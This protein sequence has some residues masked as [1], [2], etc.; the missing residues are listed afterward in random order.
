[1][2]DETIYEICKTSPKNL[3]ELY[4]IRRIK[5][6]LNIG[7]AREVLKAVNK[8]QNV[9]DKDIPQL[10]DCNKHN[11]KKDYASGQDL[12][13]VTDLMSVIVRCRA[14][15]HDLAPTILSNSSDMCKIAH[16][17]TSGIPTLSG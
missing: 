6:T 2:S 1:M 7:F 14:K 5:K 9:K 12:D 13:T 16:G 4:N 3:D 11:N 15:E 17:A 8:G 10:K